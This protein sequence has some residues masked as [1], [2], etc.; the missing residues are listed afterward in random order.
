METVEIDYDKIDFETDNALLYVIEGNNVW[1]PKSVLSDD[2]GS[3]IT[4]P[5]W[6]ADKEGLT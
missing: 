6:F 5:L 1:I 3:S 2:D 4:L